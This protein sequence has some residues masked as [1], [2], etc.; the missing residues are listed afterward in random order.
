MLIGV[1]LNA[2]SF[3]LVMLPSFLYYGGVVLHMDPFGP[4]SLIV[5]THVSFGSIAEALGVFLVGS[6]RLRKDTKGCRAEKKIMLLTII[7]WLIA[8]SLGIL[9]FTMLYL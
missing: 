8:L 5:A 7:L 1:V 9:L 2:F 4:V 3:L 6:W